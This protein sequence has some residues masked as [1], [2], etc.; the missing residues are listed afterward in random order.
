MTELRFIKDTLLKK[1][2]ELHKLGITEIGVFD[3]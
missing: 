2:G 3:S 1:K